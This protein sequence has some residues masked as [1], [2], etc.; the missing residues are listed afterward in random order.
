MILIEGINLK[1][2]L[3]ILILVK[4]DLCNTNK[5]LNNIP[6]CETCLITSND[7]NVYYGFENDQSCIIDKELCKDFIDKKLC[8]GYAVDFEYMGTYYGKE[9]NETCIVDPIFKKYPICKKCTVILEEREYSW[10]YEDGEICLL[11]LYK[12]KRTTRSNQSSYPYH[13]FFLNYV[14]KKK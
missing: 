2:V 6:S 8:I 14:S 3:I 12:C 1:L 7:T 10:S 9:F 4:I 11:D 13:I 5:I